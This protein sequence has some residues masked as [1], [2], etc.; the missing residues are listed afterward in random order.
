MSVGR[1]LTSVNSGREEL[2][3]RGLKT[4]PFEEQHFS[5]IYWSKLRAFCAEQI[6][7]GGSRE[8]TSR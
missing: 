4:A 2:D 5:V 7:A 8:T 3:F 1:P 6:P